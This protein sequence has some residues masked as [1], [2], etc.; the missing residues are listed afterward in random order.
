MIQIQKDFTMQTNY[1]ELIPQGV[2]FSLREVE[3]MNIIKVD[4]AKKLIS[5]REIEI[6]KIGNKNHIARVVLINYLTAN[7][8][9]AN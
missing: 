9:E 3:E 7:T 6:V 1:D 4:M 8:I 2:L 5:N